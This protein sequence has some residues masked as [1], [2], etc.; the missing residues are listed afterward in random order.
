MTFDLL[1]TEVLETQSDHHP[2]TDDSVMFQIRKFP[3]G[4]IVGTERRWSGKKP[5]MHED[6]E[7]P[8]DS[9][10]DFFAQITERRNQRGS[11][12][13]VNNYDDDYG[14][15]LIRQSIID[16]MRE[17]EREWSSKEFCYSWIDPEPTF[18]PVSDWS[19]LFDK[20]FE[21]AFPDPRN[22]CKRIMRFSLLGGG[23]IRQQI[24]SPA[25][26]GHKRKTR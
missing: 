19:T 16:D 13:W 17:K 1:E 9:K 7:F 21:P 20:N 2:L 10:E 23:Q 4:R 8:I 12:G 11:D 15:A 3:D 6:F 24:L 5:R 22:P 14:W 18:C 26:D 25:K